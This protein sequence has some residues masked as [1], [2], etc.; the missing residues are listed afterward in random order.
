VEGVFDVGQQASAT[1]RVFLDQ[2]ILGAIVLVLFFAIWK[3]WQQ[4]NKSQERCVE[5]ALKVTETID[6]VTSSLERNTDAIERI[7]QER[8]REEKKP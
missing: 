7:E 8:E 1:A 4:N 6:A 5:L 2:G 3:L